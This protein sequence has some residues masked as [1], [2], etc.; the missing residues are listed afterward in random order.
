MDFL[1]QSHNKNHHELVGQFQAWSL[2][3]LL[4]LL[5]LKRVPLSGA[6][7]LDHQVSQY[8]L[9]QLHRLLLNHSKDQLVVH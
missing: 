3:I 7:H 9:L 6:K 1:D 4:A 5:E 8:L 2:G